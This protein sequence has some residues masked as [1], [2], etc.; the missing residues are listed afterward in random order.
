MES[1]SAEAILSAVDKSGI[2]KM[3]NTLGGIDKILKV[4]DLSK[5]E[6]AFTKILEAVEG[7]SKQVEDFLNSF[8]G[9]DTAEKQLALI[10]DTIKSMVPSLNNLTL[11][12]ILPVVS[13]VSKGMGAMT[14]LMQSSVEKFTSV[15]KSGIEKLASV[16]KAGIDKTIA[17]FKKLP[18]G[19][20]GA[21]EKVQ[22]K[23]MDILPESVYDKIDGV[24]GKI[25]GKFSNLGSKITAPVGKM[26]ENVQLKM[27]DILPESVYDKIDG[28]AGK[29]GGM[30]SALGS[31][32][33]NGLKKSAGVGMQALSAMVKGLMSVFQLALAVIG[34]AAILGLVVIGLGAVYQQFGSQIDSMIQIV[35]TKGPEIIN[36]LVSGITSSIPAL[37][38]S[39]AKLLN[40][41]M[42]TISALLPTVVQAGMNILTAVVQGVTSNMDILLQGAIT[43]VTTLINQIISLVPQLLICGLGILMSLV[44]GILSNMNL[45]LDS[46]VSIINTFSEQMTANLPT[47]LSMGLEI[48]Q[49]LAEGIVQALPVLIVAALEAMTGFV[50]GLA[51]SLPTVLGSAVMIVTT[52][53]EGL[54]NNLPQILNAAVQFIV[55]I[56]KGIITSLP[57]VLN[58]GVQIIAQLIAGLIQSIP[59]LISTVGNLVVEVINKIK[60]TDW[61]SIGLNIISGIANG[62]SSAA[63][64]LWEAASG[65]LGGFK[66]KVLGYFG[67][68]SPS[69]WGIWV[70]KMLDVG[71]A[72][73]IDK[74]MSKV[75]NAASSLTG[76]VMREIGYL[77]DY[78]NN[79]IDFNGIV[80]SGTVA[81]GATLNA[82]DA[83]LLS[84]GA[85]FTQ[86]T[87]YVFEVPVNLDGREVGYGTA[88]Y[89]E[90]KNN[91]D[92]RRKNRLGGMTHV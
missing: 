63:G 22:L 59:A 15:Y 78:G 79:A 29:V 75:V 42:M 35:T 80:S 32:I 18:A 45:L 37:A 39:G 43:L 66:D 21:V 57:Q 90:E 50:T 65:V 77:Q 82:R 81:I 51:N 13:K 86:K 36:N 30:F 71:I 76:T 34:P 17:V 3:A 64:A 55:E 49:K 73:G 89:V 60:G 92:S 85:A 24:A 46:V 26:V 48:L 52:L 74:S 14:T 19:V 23:M 70:G 53:V 40:M 56:V 58:A 11:E 25:G 1:Y 38:E 20:H 27:M 4:N 68:H 67:I 87:R 44:D 31:G 33:G 9:A 91:F 2:S 28:A 54:I 62:I 5:I 41:L 10:T 8:A 61:R 16:S 7:S 84:N 6:G 69:R 83:E 47:I 88:E 72:G 12:K